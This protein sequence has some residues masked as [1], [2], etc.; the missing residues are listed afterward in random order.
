[1]ENDIYL[2]K[3]SYY[4]YQ[5]NKKNGKLDYS[6]LYWSILY[7]NKIKGYVF[8]NQRLQHLFIVFLGT[9][10][11]IDLAYDVNFLPVYNSL[12]EGKIHLGF[13]QM[14]IKCYASLAKTIQRISSQYIIKGYNILG[15]SMGASLSMILTFYF[16]SMINNDHGLSKTV[17][18]LFCLPKLGD[19]KFNHWYILN[20]VNQLAELNI[21]KNKMDPV[22]YLPPNCC[23]Y[24]ILDLPKNTIWFDCYCHRIKSLDHLYGRR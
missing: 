5:S 10:N 19:E 7:K 20:I 11:I 13:Y 17:V 14:F 6:W 21:Y 3:I 8:Y 24:T 18:S 9:K 15:H 12:W 4:L 16:N 2:L 23:K 22:I 1:M